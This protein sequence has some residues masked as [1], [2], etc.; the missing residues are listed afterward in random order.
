MVDCII[1]V[2]NYP[3]L[4]GYL[5]QENPELI[6]DPESD[7]ITGLA[8]TPAKRLGDRAMAYCRLMDDEEVAEWAEYP[9]VTILGQ[10]EFTGPGTADRVYSQVFED[11][12]KYAIYSE[13]YPHEEYTVELD[14]EEFTMVPPKMFGVLSGA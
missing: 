8:S 1:Y 13:L 7:E 5:K 2:E 10:S 9:T 14:G 4:L 6:E 11:E 3:I 12:D